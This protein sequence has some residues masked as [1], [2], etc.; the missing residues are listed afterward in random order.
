MLSQ[1]LK[2]KFEEIYG[3]SLEQLEASPE[4]VKKIGK[5][6]A[7]RRTL[8]RRTL[9][10]LGRGYTNTHKE[11][12]DADERDRENLEILASW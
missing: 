1:E 7:T 9:C 8:P 5:L 10:L 11:G 3:V 2:D 4:L 12:V 6:Y